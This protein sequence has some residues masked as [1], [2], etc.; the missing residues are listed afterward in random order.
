MTNT[1]MM[2][3]FRHIEIGSLPRPIIA[4]TKAFLHQIGT[5]LEPVGKN[6]EKPESV[7]FH[8]DPKNSPKT[9]IFTVR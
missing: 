8:I 4:G 2:T 3:Q 6:P 9:T 7:N 5:R 1:E